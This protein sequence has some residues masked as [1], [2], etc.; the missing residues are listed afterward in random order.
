MTSPGT[1]LSH[2][3]STHVG[4]GPTWP[5]A[6]SSGNYPHSCMLGRVQGPLHITDV[7]S[8]VSDWQGNINPFK[9]ALLSHYAHLDRSLRDQ[10]G[11]DG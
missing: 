4:G 6:L 1:A 7:K 5:S 8:T 11:N 2:F 3:S 10:S 9:T